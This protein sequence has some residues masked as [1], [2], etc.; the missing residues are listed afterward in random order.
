VSLLVYEV[1]S[2]TISALPSWGWATI[3]G[4]LLIP[5]LAEKIKIFIQTWR[6]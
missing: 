1:G 5:D 4:A 6:N 2:G 3:G